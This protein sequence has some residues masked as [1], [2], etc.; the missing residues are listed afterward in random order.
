[1]EIDLKSSKNLFSL[2]PRS[3]ARSQ[4]EAQSSIDSA[5][6]EPKFFAGPLKVKIPESIMKHLIETTE[7]VLEENKNP[8]S[9]DR[10]V[11]RVFNGR[12]S[13]GLVGKVN[14]EFTDFL[15]ACADKYTELL[16]IKDRL[17]PERVNDNKLSV[18]GIWMVSQTEDDYN[19]VH[20]HYGK[21]SG[22]IYLKVPEQIISG[23][24]EAQTGLKKFHGATDGRIE[25]I[26]WSS[27]PF[28]FT[29]R[30]H[31]VVCPLEGEMYMFPAW[32]LHTVYPF[33]GEGERRIVSFNLI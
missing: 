4:D 25:F 17:Y 7:K 23:E 15:M 28:N 27:W 31:S 12:G 6:I 18:D 22:V 21:L 10:V 9:K 33:K 30:G 24:R 5:V 8:T 1:M 3:P 32:V 20:W 13:F 11:A 16:E 14:K 19:P 26:Y 29:S 2:S